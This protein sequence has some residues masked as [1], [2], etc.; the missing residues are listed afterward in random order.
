[1]S[2]TRIRRSTRSTKVRVA[3]IAAAAAMAASACGS[4]SANG[5]T[6]NGTTAN[7]TTANGTASSSGKS[8][9]SSPLAGK[10]IDLISSGAA[11]STHDLFARAMAPGLGQYLHATVDVVDKP[12][13]GQ[14]LAW[15]YTAQAK[16]DGLTISTVD[17]EGVLANV[18]EKVPNNDVVPDKT[19]MLGGTTGVGGAAEIMFAP[20][21][22]PS[23]E[24]I[25]K[26]TK[27]V[28]EIGS[29]G[30]VPGPLLFGAYKTPYKDLT[31]YSDSSSELQG[32]L[33]GDGEVSV[34]SW[35]G[36]WAAY[37]TGGK[38]KPIMAFTLRDTWSLNPSVPTEGELL[39]KD[40]P[41]N[42]Q[43]LKAVTADTAALD[44][45]TGV[46]APPGTP[47]NI[48][49]ALT[50]GIKYAIGTTTFKTDA[51]KAQ[52]SSDYEAASAQ[53]SALQVGAAPSLVTVMRK[54]VP[55]ATGVAS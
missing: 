33:R 37:G 28:T 26:S 35:G 52:I 49:S 4:G 11:G 8:G 36:S 54:F 44:A 18:W 47:S 14:L 12:G 43:E 29:V 2:E 50:A 40:P 21:S 38:G 3:V 45:G 39:K 9:G 10:T 51:Q 15:N 27:T 46:F 41:P 55:Q 48:V 42:Q 32:M 7:G 5:T 30:D 53:Q 24:S 25:V 6:A 23:I 16:P 31:S 20:A 1:M 13:G 22:S 34:K 19:I 17:V